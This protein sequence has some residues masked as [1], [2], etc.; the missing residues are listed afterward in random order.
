MRKFTVIKIILKILNI[1]SE[2]GFMFQF[3]E[4]TMN[5]ALVDV[6]CILMWLVH[7]WERFIKFCNV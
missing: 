3:F 2:S 7:N 1:V 5:Q 6:L 4:S